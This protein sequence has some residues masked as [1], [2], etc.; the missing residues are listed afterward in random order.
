MASEH[1]YI[2][3]V[4]PSRVLRS[5]ARREPDDSTFDWFKKYADVADIIRELVPNRDARILMLGC[6]N[7][8]LSEDVR[9]HYATHLLNP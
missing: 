7:S 9:V 2:T 3:D 5:T 8:T 1:L 6:G 4:Y